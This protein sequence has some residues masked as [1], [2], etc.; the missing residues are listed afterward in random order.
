MNNTPSS[1]FLESEQIDSIANRLIPVVLVQARIVARDLIDNREAIRT[2]G[3]SS[4]AFQIGATC[5]RRNVLKMAAR[6]C[7]DLRPMIAYEYRKV[8]RELRR[9]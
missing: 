7:R 9:K 3:W 1:C 5:A 6:A 2:Y 4:V 8:R